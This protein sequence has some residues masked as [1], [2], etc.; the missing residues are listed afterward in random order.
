ME[1]KELESIMRSRLATLKQRRATLINNRRREST[2]KNHQYSP[3]YQKIE[4]EEIEEE[5]DGLILKG[6]FEDPVVDDIDNESEDDSGSDQLEDEIGSE[7][8]S[9][10]LDDNI[11]DRTPSPLLEVPKPY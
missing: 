2:V 9:K 1:D 10:Y 3:S 11:D 6:V 7:E 4:E 5:Q 8:F